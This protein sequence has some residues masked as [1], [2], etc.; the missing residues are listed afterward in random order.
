MNATLAAQAAALDAAAQLARVHGQLPG[1]RIE[2]SYVHPG[3]IFVSLHNDL[4]EFEA[5]REALG[6]LAADVR[7]EDHTPGRM[8]LTATCTFAGVEIELTGYAPAITP[9]RVSH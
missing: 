1:A 8:S 7:R 9:D 6:I 5:W 4:G 2:V 3:R